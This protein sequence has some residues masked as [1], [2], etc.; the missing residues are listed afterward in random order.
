M[1]IP[2]F[3]RLSPF[4]ATLCFSLFFLCGAGR[5]IDDLALYARVSPERYR[6]R[7]E[8]TVKPGKN[9]YAVYLPLPGDTLLQKIDNLNHSEGEEYSPP[10]SPGEKFLKVVVRPDVSK[11]GEN[12][13]VEF[14]VTLWSVRVDF[15]KIS[16]IHPYD[17][18]SELYREYTREESPHFDLK[19]EKVVNVVKE[20]T[21]ASKDDLD[22]VRKAY[23]H[24]LDTIEFMSG[25]HPAVPPLADVLKRNRGSSIQAAN[26]FISLLRQRGIPARIACALNVSGDDRQWQE[27]YLEKYGWVPVFIDLAQKYADPSSFFGMAVPPPFWHDR[28]PHCVV[29]GYTLSGELPGADGSKPA[30]KYRSRAK[31]HFSGAREEKTRISI[32]KIEGLSN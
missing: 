16:A 12:V 17:K 9:D 31:I 19:H 6:I 4:V 3:S 20:L 5:A 24:T 22:F 15:E 30:V 29:L 13:F 25:S 23:F 1:A 8:T 28:Q 11:S 2:I 18:K 32:E 10:A 14:E 26:Y 27:F 7:I 21:A